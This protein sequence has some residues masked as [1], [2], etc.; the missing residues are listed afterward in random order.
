M[1]LSILICTIPCRTAMFGRLQADLWGQIL[2]YAGQIEVLSDDHPT[3]SIGA[4]RNRLL[5]RAAGEFVTMIDDDDRISRNYIKLLMEGICNDVDCCSLLG[6]ITTDGED[7]HYF[8]H[9]INYPEYKTNANTDFRSGGVKYE[10]Y[11]NHIS[12]LKSCVAK[13][14]RFPETN[15]GEDTDWAT[16]IKNSGLLL[17]EHQIN[18]VLYYY[19][20]ISNKQKV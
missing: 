5:E 15:W 16:Q 9:S 20:F 12:C 4:K 13:A 8:E 1:K 11:P 18:E 10:R 6:V 2:P 19:D 7:P 3:D 14:F 17:R